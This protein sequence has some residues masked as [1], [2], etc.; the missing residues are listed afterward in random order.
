MKRLVNGG[1]PPDRNPKKIQRFAAKPVVQPKRTKTTN[2]TNK[3]YGCLRYLW[4][5]HPTRRS[6]AVGPALGMTTEARM[7][8]SP[9]TL[10]LSS[11]IAYATVVQ[12]ATISSV[13]APNARRSRSVGSFDRGMSKQAPRTVIAAPLMCLAPSAEYLA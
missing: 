13:I 9:D 4:I 3:A 5:P 10:T 2:P 12:V 6:R 8:G 7:K 11:S 1:T